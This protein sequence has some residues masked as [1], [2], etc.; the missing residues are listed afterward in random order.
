MCVLLLCWFVYCGGG[1]LVLE[2]MLVG[3]WLVVKLGFK[4]VE[5]DVM[6][7]GDGMLV[8]IYDEML[9]WM[10]SGVGC[11]CVMLDVIFFLFD[12]GNGEWIFCF[13]EVVVLCCE[14][15]LL[16]NVEIKLV[17]GYE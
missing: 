12:V 13:V 8:F 7:S 11:V 3:I 10:M 1:L 16:V 4:V 6:L 15:G 2:N 9:E 17:I 14:F 5:F